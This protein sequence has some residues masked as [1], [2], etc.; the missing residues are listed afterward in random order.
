MKVDK[1]YVL[2]INHT[3]EKIDNIVSRLELA[4]F[5]PNTPFVVLKGH[6]AY[7]DEVP[8]GVE[9]YEKWG[10][11][12][13]WNKFWQMPVQTGEVGCTL[14]H[15]NAWKIIADE[16]VE[17]A[18]ILEE[19]FQPVN[20]MQFKDIPEPNPKWP[21]VWDYLT[22]GRWSFNYDDDIKLNETYCIPGLHYNMHSYILTNIGAQ[23][24]VD[25]NLEKNLFIND[26]FITAT[27]MKHRRSDIEKMYPVK[28]INALATHKDLFE[29]L[30][31]KSMVSGHTRD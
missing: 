21:F 20:G 31:H 7:T 17:R 14:S 25:Y 11:S 19:D 24:L 5:E 4:G 12:N 1:I 3:Q 26:E 15:I 10:I 2:A 13:S 18:L 9:V 6:N 28:T 27:Y 29:Q 16:G 22:L 8:E 30:D 23:K